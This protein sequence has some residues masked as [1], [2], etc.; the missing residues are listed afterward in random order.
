M[1]MKQ[2]QTTKPKWTKAGESSVENALDEMKKMTENLA[3]KIQVVV[4]IDEKPK[5]NADILREMSASKIR[6]QPLRLCRL[7]SKPRRQPV[8]QRNLV[9]REVQRPGKETNGAIRKGISGV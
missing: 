5:Q 6:F 3:E 8:Q 9:I 1:N 2:K 4:K 7:R